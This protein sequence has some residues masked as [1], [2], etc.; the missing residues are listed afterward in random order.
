MAKSKYDPETFPALAEGYAREGLIDKEIAAKLGVS[1]DSF[2][3]YLKRHSEFSE[4]IKR[5]KAPVDFAVESALLRR[6]LGGNHTVTTR[7]NSVGRLFV[8]REVTREV[9]P[10]VAAAIFWLRNRRPDKWRDPRKD[11]GSGESE[12]GAAPSETFDGLGGAD[13]REG[14]FV[15][16]QGAGLVEAPAEPLGE[17]L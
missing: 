3:E 2:Y 13:V 1:E 4:S 10:D 6:A 14:V 12:R 16:P 17:T 7:E 9:L 15:A 5:G 8:S 11:G